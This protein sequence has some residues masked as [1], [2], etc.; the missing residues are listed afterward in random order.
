MDCTIFKQHSIIYAHECDEDLEQNESSRLQASL[1]EFTARGGVLIRMEGEAIPFSLKAGD[2]VF[3][4]CSGANN[5]SQTLWNILQLYDGVISLQPPH[6]TRYGLDPYNGKVNWNRTTHIHEDD[7]FIKWAGLCKSPKFGWNVFNDYFLKDTATPGDLNAITEYYNTHY[8]KPAVPFGIRR[9]YITF[10]KNAH[11]HLYRLNQTNS[12][13]D[14]V[15]VLFYPIDDLIANPLP[16]WE[17]PPRSIK[18]YRELA[19]M[20]EKYL[21]FSR[22]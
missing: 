9:V 1:S 16:E 6:A 2:R 22:I 11:V 3:P 18:A 21:D 17:T 4:S 15:V 14:N 13:L 7:E 12:T 8:F 5:R 19:F 10:S 20:L